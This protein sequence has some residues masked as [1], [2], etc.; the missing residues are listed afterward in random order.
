MAR[1]TTQHT[2]VVQ[3]ANLEGVVRR[4]AIADEAFSPGHLLRFDADEELEKH[5]TADGVLI[6]KLVAAINPTPDTITYPTTAA[7]DI[8][9]TADDMAYYI[10]GQPGD[11]LMIYLE[12][13]ETVVKGVSQL[14]SNG[15][16]TLKVV[17]VGTSTLANSVVGVADEDATASGDTLIRVRIT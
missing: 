9:Y 15:G 13:A 1:T 4:E 5:N 3:S 6:G 14:V 16:G 12:D 2:I 17:T 10:E 8:P 11:I 7:V